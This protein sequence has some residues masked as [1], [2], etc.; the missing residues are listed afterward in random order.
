ME[1]PNYLDE[2]RPTRT[3]RRI[4]LE[5]DGFDSGSSIEYRIRERDRREEGRGEENLTGGG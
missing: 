2:Y 1:C 4:S 3:I 5:V